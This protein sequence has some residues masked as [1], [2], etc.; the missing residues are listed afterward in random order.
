LLREENTGNVSSNRLQEQTQ[1]N[2]EERN[3][4]DLIR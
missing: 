1:L 3:E 2:A 4:D